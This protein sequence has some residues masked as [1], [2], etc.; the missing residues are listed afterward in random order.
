MS[1]VRNTGP[2]SS[3]KKPQR[4]AYSAETLGLI[5]LCI[6]VLVIIV[7]RYWGHIDWSAR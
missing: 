4:S 6:V 2:T 7:I 3:D 5:I 1:A